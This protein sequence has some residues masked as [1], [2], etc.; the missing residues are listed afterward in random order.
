[1]SSILSNPPILEKITNVKNAIISYASGET[2]ITP[3][4]KRCVLVY[5]LILFFTL[6]TA[7]SLYYVSTDNNIVNSEKYIYAF[8]TFI[9]LILIIVASFFIFNKNIKLFN[10]IAGLCMVGIVF[11]FLYYFNKISSFGKT[12][13]IFFNIILQIIIFSIILV[14]LA[15]VFSIFEKKI[16]SL[17]GPSG[18]FV[19]LIFLIPCLL[20]EFIEYIKNQLKITPN[21]TFVLFI[22]EIIFILLYVYVPYL[23]NIKILKET[24]KPLLKDSLFLNTKT[25]IAK[26]SDLD[27]INQNNFGNSVNISQQSSDN[28]QNSD[29][30][31]NYAFSMWIYL[32]EQQPFSSEKT[33]FKYG[34]SCPMISFTNTKSNT[35]SN[36]EN[37]NIAVNSSETMV[38]KV[39]IPRQKWNHI[40]FNYNNSSVDIF[41]NGNLERTVIFNGDNPTY[42]PV[43]LVSVGDDNGV[44]GA[45]CNVE[46]YSTPLTQFQIATK[47][48]ILMN[49]NPPT[50]Y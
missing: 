9:P 15:I 45:I 18:L 8:I 50:N 34:S 36:T 46:F 37:I 26:T 43:D 22:I 6:L 33:I 17:R 31:Q 39:E 1:M 24:G 44:N 3:E 10:L 27:P 2:T 4:L 12:Y 47:Y 21:I 38:Y 20:T 19:N 16:R 30:R 7:I 5:G 28:I 35:K 32:N 25:N 14:G 41:I 29:I 49:K 48:N 40:V 23:F 42:S 11:I 13:G